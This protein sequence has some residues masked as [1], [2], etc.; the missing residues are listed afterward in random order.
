MGENVCENIPTDD[1]RPHLL[2]LDGHGSHVFNLPFLK[3]MKENNIHLV[4]FPPHTT[5]WLQ[6]ADKSFFKSLKHSWTESGRNFMRQAAGKKPDR[7]E[8][9]ELFVPA[10]VK[11]ATVETAQSGF[12][13]TGMFPVN[14]SAVPQH[15][16]EPSLTTE[17]P[18]QNQDEPAA[19]PTAYSGG[20]TTA[21]AAVDRPTP[22]FAL[23]QTVASAV[24]SV[25]LTASLA[26]AP[27]T[28]AAGTITNP[29]IAVPVPPSTSLSA[30]SAASALVDENQSAGCSSSSFFEARLP[31]PVRQRSLKARPRAKLASFVLTSSEHI[32]T[33]EVK[34]AKNAMVTSAKNNKPEKPTKTTKTSESTK[35]KSSIPKQKRGSKKGGNVH[36]NAQAN[37]SYPANYYCSVCRG[38]YGDP[39][40]PKATDDWIECWKCHGLFHES[41]GEACGVLEDDDTFTCRTC[42]D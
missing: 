34:D 36:D 15:A 42:F 24:H 2:L 11:S 33:V 31:V 3:L 21:V 8:F 4:C 6:P 19:S 41:C 37:S 9:F 27:S 29:A 23:L 25:D 40:D 10:W 1:P 14:D 39:A 30:L 20:T 32:S 38:R 18:L 5:H 22:S 16:F 7:K 17:R 13:E 26:T 35:S 12:R 28:L